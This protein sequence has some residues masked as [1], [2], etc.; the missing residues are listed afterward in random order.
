MGGSSSKKSKDNLAGYRDPASPP[1]D[2]RAPG[3]GKGI[4]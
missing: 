2:L 1:K 3:D 4:F